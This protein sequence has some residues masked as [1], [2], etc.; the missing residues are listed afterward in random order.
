[1]RR[2]KFFSRFQFVADRSSELL[3]FSPLSYSG[4]FKCC[5][6]VFVTLVYQFFTRFSVQLLSAADIDF[7]LET[8]AVSFEFSEFKQSLGHAILNEGIAGF[9]VVWTNIY[10]E[11][12]RPSGKNRKLFFQLDCK[13]PLY[14]V[15]EAKKGYVQFSPILNIEGMQ[16]MIF[17]K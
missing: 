11:R 3:F 5:N 13:I 1:M 9:F 10:N 6:D 16:Y 2:L 4:P 8:S 17:L 12:E 15:L 7:N 14:S